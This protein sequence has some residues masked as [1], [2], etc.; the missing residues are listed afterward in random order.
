MCYLGHR[1]SAGYQAH[2]KRSPQLVKF[3]S[4][5]HHGVYQWMREARRKKKEQTALIKEARMKK[6]MEESLAAGEPTDPLADKIEQSTKI[7]LTS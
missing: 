1:N 5:G 6:M 2:R 7:E 3:L 4:F